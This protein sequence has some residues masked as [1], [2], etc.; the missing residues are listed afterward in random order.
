M[1]LLGNFATPVLILSVSSL[2]LQARNGMAY[3]NVS[4]KN[5][6]C[7]C[8]DDD[9]NSYQPRAP[10]PRPA[11]E[12]PNDSVEETSRSTTVHQ[13]Q[14]SQKVVPVIRTC[15]ANASISPKFV[16]RSDWGAANFR[17]APRNSGTS[18]A[19]QIILSQTGSPSCRTKDHCAFLLKMFQD[20]PSLQSTLYD[21]NFNF[22]VGG[23]GMVYLGRGWDKSSPYDENEDDKS[24]E[25]SLIGRFGNVSPTKEQLTAVKRL[26]CLGMREDKIAED[27]DLLDYV[28]NGKPNMMSLGVKVLNMIKV[29]G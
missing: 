15:N 23:D 19:T 20:E 3:R 1:R 25:I 6:Q 5:C 16:S 7:V 13:T 22:L 9:D 8:V 4:L 24:I 11:P 26:I 29:W 28:Q 14:A 10:V 18:P 12:E 2:L 21:V 17:K 27:Y